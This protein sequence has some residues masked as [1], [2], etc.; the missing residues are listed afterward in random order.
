M[1]EHQERV[2][3][4]CSNSAIRG[5]LSECDSKG[6][7]VILTGDGELVVEGPE[8]AMTPSLLAKLKAAKPDLLD[9]A[10][11]GRTRQLAGPRPCLHHSDPEQWETSPEKGRP[12]W[13]RVTCR[14]CGKFI[15]CRPWSAKQS[16]QRL[17]VATEAA[18]GPR[19]PQDATQVVAATGRSQG[20]PN[21]RSGATVHC[22]T[23]VSPGD[24]RQ[25]EANTTTPGGSF[26][27]EIG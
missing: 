16:H 19:T 22:D 6:V 2:G 21:R 25:G 15:G 5:L 17:P 18:G 26:P 10:V 8:D 14:H 27:V 7:Q 23:N 9:L 13:V 20:V 3:L 24:G 4:A 12:G 1:T 11:A